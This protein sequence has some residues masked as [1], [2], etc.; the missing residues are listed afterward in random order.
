MKYL[1]NCQISFPT[2]F[3][4]T[5]S[6]G[7]STYC[8]DLGRLTMRGKVPDFPPFGMI[9]TKLLHRSWDHDP[10]YKIDDQDAK[11]KAISDLELISSPWI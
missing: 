11:N 1:H 5:F 4:S 9:S 8:N 6:P 3:T 7:I 10:Q 2:L